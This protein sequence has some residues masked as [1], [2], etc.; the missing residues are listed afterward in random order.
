MLLFC[1]VHTANLSLLDQVAPDVFDGEVDPE[2][3]ERC[4]ADPDR[5]QLIALQDG[6]VVGQLLAAFHRHVDKPAECYVDDLGV[7][8]EFQRQGI[9]A[10]LMDKVAAIAKTE[11]IDELWLG[12]ESDNAGAQAF[13]RAIGME[14]RT[15]FLYEWDPQDRD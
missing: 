8:P 4:L 11:G 15:A 5:I 1:R 12:T 9:A 3:A 14:E 7:A 10:R 13:Y 6:L 2:L